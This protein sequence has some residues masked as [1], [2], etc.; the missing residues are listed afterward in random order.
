MHWAAV[1]MRASFL[2]APCIGQRVSVR[3]TLLLAPTG[4]LCCAGATRA[5]GAHSKARLCETAGQFLAGR[6][7]CI[8]VN[9]R[10]YTEAAHASASA[11]ERARKQALIRFRARYSTA[12][13]LHQEGSSNV[14]ITFHQRSPARRRRTLACA[15]SCMAHADRVRNHE[16]RALTISSLS[17]PLPSIK[18]SS[19]SGSRI[20][21]PDASAAH[22]PRAPL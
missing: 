15:Y 16:V 14:I 13:H 19:N 2:L 4:V 21:P 12:S 8:G 17:R 5:R 9:G 11:R 10:V 6:F 7:S 3:A 18:R 1:S 22:T 20:H